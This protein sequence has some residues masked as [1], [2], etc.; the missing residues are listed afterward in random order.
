MTA[1]TSP[2]GSHVG[3]G[4]GDVG[5]DLPLIGVHSVS[6]AGTPGKQGIEPLLPFAVGHYASALTLEPFLHRCSD[7][8]GDRLSALSTEL[9]QQGQLP[10][11][12]VD[13]RPTHPYTIHHAHVIQD[14]RQAGCQRISPDS[15]GQQHEWIYG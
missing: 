11:V 4:V 13:V 15:P 10:I 6:E 5:S 1:R 12:K 2:L 7:Q 9:L 3:H 14:R 8:P